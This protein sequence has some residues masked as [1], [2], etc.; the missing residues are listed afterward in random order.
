MKER[1][2]VLHEGGVFPDFELTHPDRSWNPYQ[3]A[4]LSVDGEQVGVVKLGLLMLPPLPHGDSEQ[5]EA[6]DPSRNARFVR[7]AV[8]GLR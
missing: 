2:T 6:R 3:R 1:F 8:N 5:Q 4:D 7:M